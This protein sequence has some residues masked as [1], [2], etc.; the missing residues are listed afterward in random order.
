[1]SRFAN[2]ELL[3]SEVRVRVASY[4][5]RSLIKKTAWQLFRVQTVDFCSLEL[6]VPIRFDAS[7]DSCGI[8]FAS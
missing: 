7:R 2:N 6:A 4:P 5:G 3:G 8:S 1:M